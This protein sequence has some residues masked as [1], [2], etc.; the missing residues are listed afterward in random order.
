[1]K[2][3]M[4]AMAAEAVAVV[5]L[6]VGRKREGGKVKGKEGGREGGRE[7][8]AAALYLIMSRRVCTATAVC[9]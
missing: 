5:I 6:G 8:K 3:E 4:N 7:G 2:M 1:M 9:P